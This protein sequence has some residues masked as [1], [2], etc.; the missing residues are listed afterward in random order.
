MAAEQLGLRQE[1]FDVVCMASA[2]YLLHQQA[3]VLRAL[4]DLL[5]P[6]RRLAVSDF[7]TRP[8]CPVG[9][10]V[11][12]SRGRDTGHLSSSE[13]SFASPVRLRIRS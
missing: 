4:R 8:R 7:A 5:R 3:A 13:G 2:I 12:K 9:A 6:R 11:T 1:S 10:G